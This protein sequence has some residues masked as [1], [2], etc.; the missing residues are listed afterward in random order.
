M[1]SATDATGAYRRAPD[2]ADVVDSAAG[3]G[4]VLLHLASGRRTVLSETATA[5]W[6]AVVAAGRDGVSAGELAP[7]LAAHFGADPAVVHADVA[8]LLA[9]LLSAE[10]L[11]P[12][13]TGDGPGQAGK[14]G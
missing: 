10:L 9:E 1:T 2:V 5:V 14:A 4:A 13:S 8:R 7:P 11:E 12:A 3:G 6:Q